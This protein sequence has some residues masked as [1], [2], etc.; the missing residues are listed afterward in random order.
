MLYGQQS[1]IDRGLPRSFTILPPPPWPS[2]VGLCLV[3]I[4]IVFLSLR[5]ALKEYPRRC[6]VAW[7]AWTLVL[8]TTL[9]FPAALSHAARRGLAAKLLS[10]SH[11]TPLFWLHNDQEPVDDV[12]P[13]PL[14]L[15]YAHRDEVRAITPA[16]LVDLTGKAEPFSVVGAADAV[17]GEQAQLL[18]RDEELGLALWRYRGTGVVE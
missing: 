5:W 16:Q 9:A 3:L 7:T 18:R 1:L 2:V 17:V 13:N 10:G 4:T 14:V 6:H 15:L 12:V 11:D 8:M